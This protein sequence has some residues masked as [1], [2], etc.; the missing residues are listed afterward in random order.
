MAKKA[1]GFEGSPADVREDKKQARA[2]GMSLKQWEK[3]SADKKHDR[4]KRGGRGR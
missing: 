4:P 3:S 2:R 1:K